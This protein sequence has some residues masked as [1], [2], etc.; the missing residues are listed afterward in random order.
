MRTDSVATRR[1]VYFTQKKKKKMK[2]LFYEKNICHMAAIYNLAYTGPDD[3]R[4]KDKK[5]SST[6]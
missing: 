5:M 3:F 1:V 2:H 6:L 4:D